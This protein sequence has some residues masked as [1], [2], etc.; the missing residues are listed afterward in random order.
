MHI[1]NRTRWRIF[2]RDRFTCRYCG[3]R[4]PSV[5]LAVDHVFPRS[6]GGSND[7]ENLAT[8]CVECNGSKSNRPLPSPFYDRAEYAERWLRALFPDECEGLKLPDARDVLN[9]ATLDDME[10]VLN[11]IETFRPVLL[12][13][14]DVQGDACTFIIKSLRRYAWLRGWWEWPDDEDMDGY[15]R[16]AG[17][18]PA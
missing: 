7:W 13:D 9:N 11:A 5:E 8:A 12:D 3:R 10:C 14:A 4:S 1:S 18:Q 2:E 6:L 16:V 17:E 15:R